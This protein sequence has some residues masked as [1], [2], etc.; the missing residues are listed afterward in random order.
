[1]PPEIEPYVPRE[2][3]LGIQT[4]DFVANLGRLMAFYAPVV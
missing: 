4:S 3:P 1:V 2:R